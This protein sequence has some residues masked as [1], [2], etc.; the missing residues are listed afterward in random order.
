MI[1]HA[2]FVPVWN[3]GTGVPS[4]EE[5]ADKMGLP[6]T[7]VYSFDLTSLPVGGAYVPLIGGLWYRIKLKGVIDA[8]TAIG[9]T[10]PNTVISLR[11]VG[12]KAAGVPHYTAWNTYNMLAGSWYT[13]N[14]EFATYS[15]QS[16]HV[17]IL[18]GDEQVELDLIMSNSG[19]KSRV[20][21]VKMPVAIPA[22]LTLTP[23]Q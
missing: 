2:D 4:Y 10:L 1:P 19:V 18:C 8:E 21:V 7:K 16:S 3:G 6:I 20:T 12:T 17:T 23:P 13:I 22:Q 11:E 14:P 9:A 15:N 5:L